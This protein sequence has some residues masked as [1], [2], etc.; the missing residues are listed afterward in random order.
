MRSRDRLATLGKQQLL[1]LRVCDLDLDIASSRLAPRIRELYRELARHRFRFKPHFWLSDDWF[2][3]DGV[4]GVAIPFYLAHPKLTQLERAMTMDVEGGDRQW[5]MNLLRHETAHALLNAYRLDRRKDWRRVF[6]NPTK[7][8]PDTYW[9][10][11]YDK[12]FVLNLP[13]WYAQSHP[14]EDWA[15]TFAVWLRPNSNW[16]RRYADWPAIR[17]L[18]FIDRL[19]AEIREQPPK[20]RNRQTEHPVRRIKTTLSD[21]Y[22]AKLARYD[23]D[24]PEFIDRDLYKLFGHPKR[25]ARRPP[26]SAFLLRARKEVIESVENW[27]GEYRYRIDRT[28]RRMAVRCDELGLE[29]SWNEDQVKIEL[30]A[31]LTMLVVNKMLKD[32]FHIT[33]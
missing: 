10:R 16:R 23:A 33:L 6:G 21:Y 29:L 32:G 5:C 7:K 13:N 1:A 8:Y 24:G 11:P 26:A 9:P 27:G 18:R 14:H 31:C 4:P 2:C 20:L 15:E 12:R 25:G 3:P 22:K 28:L 19:M 17:K 30:V